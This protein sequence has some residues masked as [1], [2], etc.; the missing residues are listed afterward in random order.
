MSQSPSFGR[1][2][3]CKS[4]DKQD[5][6]TRHE[7]KFTNAI[8]QHNT[9]TTRVG[10]V[11]PHHQFCQPYCKTDGHSHHQRHH[12]TEMNPCAILHKMD[13]VIDTASLI[14]F[15]LKHPINLLEFDDVYV[16][17]VMCLRLGRLM[18]VCTPKPCRF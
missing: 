2:G 5:Q 18:T 8:Q 17:K 3:V 13:Q 14:K 7:Q 10:D 4:K 12:H 1:L 15:V 16:L 9:K 11:Y 6:Y